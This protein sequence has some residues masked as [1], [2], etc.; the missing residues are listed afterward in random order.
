MTANALGVD[1]PPSAVGGGG[2][3]QT[4]DTSNSAPEIRSPSPKRHP[5]IL[6]LGLPDVGNTT[7]RSTSSTSTTSTTSVLLDHPHLGH[8][9]F[10]LL[11]TTAP[12]PPRANGSSLAV[13]SSSSQHPLSVS[14]SGESDEED[15]SPPSGE[16]NVVDRTP[17]KSR[18]RISDRAGISQTEKEDLVRQIVELL[19]EEEEEQVKDVLKP[20]LGDLA[21]VC[22]QRWPRY[23]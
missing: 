23:L 15:T 6:G 19:D 17:Q 18:P 16:G 12:S 8:Y 9:I 7:D 20:Y 4:R 3:N 1:S 2:G 22:C 21:K 13:S 14:S 10:N 5:N 11:A